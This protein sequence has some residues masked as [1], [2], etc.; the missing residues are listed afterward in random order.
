MRGPVGVLL[1]HARAE[2]VGAVKT[3]YAELGK[4]LSPCSV[5]YVG[6]ILG[7]ALKDAAEW[8]R[9]VWNPCELRSLRRRRN[10]VGGR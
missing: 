10:P 9:I 4:K 6:A 1:A 5:R 7:H 2:R 3:M 8:G